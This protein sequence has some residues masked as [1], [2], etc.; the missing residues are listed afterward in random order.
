M[1]ANIKENQELMEKDMNFFSGKTEKV[2]VLEEE[3]AIIHYISTP[4][5]DRGGDIV[6]PKGMDDSDFS[7]SPS[8]WYN[9]EYRWNPHALPVGKSLWR[10]KESGG[11][12]AKTQFNSLDFSQDVYS[13]HKNGDMETWSI[14]WSPN[15][16]FKDAM[17]YNE[18]EETLYI[19]K[20][21][22]FEYSSAPIAMNPNAG[23][24]IK[25]LQEMQ[26]KSITMKNLINNLEVEVDVKEQ[27]EQMQKQ[28]DEL[29]AS[30][31]ALE[32]LIKNPN[33][34]IE[35]LSKE[36]EEIKKTIEEKEKMVE[37]EIKTNIEEPKKVENLGFTDEQLKSLLHQTIAGEFSRLKGLE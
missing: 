11:I 33:G 12:L 19:Y 6:D 36:I 24:K 17:K 4:D 2:E 25:A 37:E 7:K 10:K 35:K 29:Q 21:L 3:K 1:K 14:G 30:Y 15:R 5:K 16:K 9:H 34:D 8:V 23:D 20:W 22:L 28:F 13:L 26:F 31:K 27:V 32:E 18:D